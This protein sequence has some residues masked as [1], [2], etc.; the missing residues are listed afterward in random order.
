MSRLSTK[1]LM[2]LLVLPLFFLNLLL[3]A[4]YTAVITNLLGVSLESS[5]PEVARI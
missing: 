4:V 2:W 5:L 3:N 1:Q